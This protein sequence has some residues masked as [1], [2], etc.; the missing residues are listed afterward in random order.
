MLATS[1]ANHR[2]GGIGRL[3]ALRAENNAQAVGHGNLAVGLGENAVAAEVEE[4]PT[5]KV[6]T[7]ELRLRG[8]TEAATVSE[9]PEGMIS[10]TALHRWVVGSVAALALDTAGCLMA[11]ENGRIDPRLSQNKSREGSGCQ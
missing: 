6:A 3:D 11:G 5:F 7:T 1:A 2:T 4:C 10:D 8:F 9:F